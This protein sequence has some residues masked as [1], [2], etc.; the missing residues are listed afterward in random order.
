MAAALRR[1]ESERRQSALVIHEH[2]VTDGIVTPENLLEEV[3]SEIA[4]PSPRSG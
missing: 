1:F 2:R 3:V 4:T